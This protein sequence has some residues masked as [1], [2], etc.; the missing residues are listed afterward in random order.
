MF[1]SYGFLFFK[2]CINVISLQKEKKKKKEKAARDSPAFLTV[3]AK[4]AEVCLFFWMISLPT[5]LQ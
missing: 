1:G 5:L 3:M 2:K 4:A